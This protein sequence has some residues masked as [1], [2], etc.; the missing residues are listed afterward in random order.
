M[1][2]AF[3]FFGKNGY[4]EGTSG[5]I[6]VRDPILPDHFWMNP[7]AVHFS[8]LKASDM[9]L[10]DGEGYVVKGGNQA[11]INEAGFMIHYEVVVLT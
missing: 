9:V 8:Q 4:T 10:V 2:A 7:F 3:R 11:M 6:S 5:H 1:A